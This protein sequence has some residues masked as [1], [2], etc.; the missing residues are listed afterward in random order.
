[1]SCLIDEEPPSAGTSAGLPEE[2]EPTAPEGTTGDLATSFSHH[3][4]EEGGPPSYHV[5]E[6]TEEIFG[7]ELTPGEVV[8]LCRIN[9]NNPLCNAF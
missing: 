6:G 9:I 4:I 8:R 2:S 1:M 7:V 5:M 3:V